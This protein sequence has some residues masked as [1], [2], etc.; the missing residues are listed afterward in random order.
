M[1]DVKPNSEVKT[2]DSLPD[3]LILKVIG[4]ASSGERH[5]EGINH[6]F[7]LNVMAKISKRF[8][9]ISTDSSLWRGNVHIKASR[10]DTKLAITGINH[11]TTFLKIRIISGADISSD[12]LID[13][14]KRCT[15]LKGLDIMID[16]RSWPIA[17]SWTSMRF[18]KLHLT[19]D[20]HPE[21]FWD[22]DMGQ[23]PSSQT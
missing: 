20:V 6:N 23:L 21:Y 11:G 8:Q 18:L 16:L 2:I 15:N 14:Y 12:D 17:D 3:E 1:E 19:R 5:G 7:I 4:L 10:H 13:I 9:R 22:G